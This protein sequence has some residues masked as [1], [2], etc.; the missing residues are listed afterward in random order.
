M[1]R[2]VDDQTRWIMGTGHRQR[3]DRDVADRLM[4]ALGVK[5]SEI[6]TQAPVQRSVPGPRAVD[7][8]ACCPR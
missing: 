6:V 7:P 2:R 4:A 1:D 5:A 8:S 3:V